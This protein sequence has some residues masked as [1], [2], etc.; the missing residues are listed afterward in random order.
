MAACENI[1]CKS[2]YDV[3]ATY[4]DCTQLANMDKGFIC[5]IH[6]NQQSRCVGMAQACRYVTMLSGPPLVLASC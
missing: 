6:A 3:Q 1:L 4:Q 5:L 2:G